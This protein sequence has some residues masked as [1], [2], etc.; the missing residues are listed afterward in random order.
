[1]DM[2]MDKVMDVVTDMIV[3]TLLLQKFI[4]DFDLNNCFTVKDLDV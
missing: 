2:N 3:I 4:F 1:M